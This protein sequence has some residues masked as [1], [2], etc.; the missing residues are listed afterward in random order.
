MIKYAYAIN[1]N[2]TD[3]TGIIN[4]ETQT[5]VCF[6]TEENS[7]VLLK[8]LNDSLSE[9]IKINGEYKAQRFLNTYTIDQ[10]HRGLV[11]NAFM[12][13]YAARG[14]EFVAVSNGPIK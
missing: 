13:G 5:V 8:S 4:L 7:K 12:A 3:Q 9:A 6:C 14:E 1:I 2:G 10:R 11:Y